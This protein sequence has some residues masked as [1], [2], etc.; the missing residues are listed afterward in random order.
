[1]KR[2]PREKEAE[3]IQLRGRGVSVEAVAEKVGVSRSTVYNVLARHQ[4]FADEAFVREL[5]GWL[6]VFRRLWR[7]G[8]EGIIPLSPHAGAVARLFR[9]YG[10]LGEE[11]VAQAV[12]N[13]NWGALRARRRDRGR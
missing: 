5:E 7:D 13:A 9:E 4:S 8:S 11:L 2:I 10:F 3:I 12:L 6:E 1:L